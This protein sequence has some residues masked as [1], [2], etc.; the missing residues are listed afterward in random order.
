LEAPELFSNDTVWYLELPN[1][2]GYYT[3][4][5]YGITNDGCSASASSSVLIRDDFGFYIP[6]SFTPNGDGINDVFLPIF[7]YSPDA[8]E[9][10]IVDRWG[11][12][13]W[14]TTDPTQAWTGNAYNGAHY[15]RDGTYMWMMQYRDKSLEA[16]T[17]QGYVCILR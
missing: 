1:Q 15:V 16:R 12:C 17:V 13:I 11:S 2:S 14:Q 7:T 4:Q 8:Y 3:I 10:C 5:L 6:N 9:F